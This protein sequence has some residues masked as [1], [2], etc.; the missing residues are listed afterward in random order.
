M[1]ADGSNKKQLTAD[2]GN[3]WSPSPAGDGRALAFMSDR[4]GAPE[5]WLMD[6]D[7]GNPKRLPNFGQPAN[8]GG[9]QSHI[10]LSSDGK[11]AV[12]SRYW[13]WAFKVAADNTVPIKVWGRCYES[14]AAISPD[15]RMVLCDSTAAWAMP[16]RA[17]AR[18]VDPQ[19]GPVKILDFESSDLI[20]S[21][22][23][24]SS[25]VTWAADS[26]SLMYVVTDGGISNIWAGVGSSL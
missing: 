13:A 19:A 7:G 16:A 21:F 26:Q 10:S 2:S 23:I 8:L 22:D 11:W 14:R 5:A 15:G 25:S 6:T 12:Q 4:S 18:P 3:N 17:K 24:H 9:D 1:D 20:K